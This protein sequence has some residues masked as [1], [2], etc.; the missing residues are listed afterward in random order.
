MRRSMAQSLKKDLAINLLPVRVKRH[1]TSKHILQIFIND[2]SLS[3]RRAL[4]FLI[5]ELEV[6][7]KR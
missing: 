1:E 7:A 2:Q 3:H 5:G 6:V 4:F